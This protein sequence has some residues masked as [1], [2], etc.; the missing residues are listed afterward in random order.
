LSNGEIKKLEEAGEDAHSLK[1]K[2]GGSRFDL[3]KDSN[4]NVYEVLKGGRGEPNPMNI[5]IK[6][7]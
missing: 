1:G 5:N 2:K 3:Y 6:D 4:G 7:L